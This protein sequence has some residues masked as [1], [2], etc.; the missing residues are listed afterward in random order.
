MTTT[1]LERPINKKV[2]EEL[3]LPT[4]WYGEEV[5][6]RIIS[7]HKNSD[8]KRKEISKKV[9]DKIRNSPNKVSLKYDK[10]KKVFIVPRN[11]SKDFVDWVN[12]G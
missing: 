2:I 4:E 9:I 11:A 6:M 7:E 12:N 8:T 10:S 1:V 5:E 3:D